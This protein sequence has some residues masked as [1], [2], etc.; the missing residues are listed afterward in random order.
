MRSLSEYMTDVRNAIEEYRETMEDIDLEIIFESFQCKML[1]DI[2]DQL[3]TIIKKRKDEQAEIDKKEYKNSWERP[4]VPAP[5]ADFKQMFFW[6]DFTWDKI[7]DS[8]VKEWKAGDPNGMKLVKRICSN[9]S[10]SIPGMIILKSE[11]NSE[12][13]FAG[14]IIKA[15]WDIRYYSLLGQYHKLNGALKPKEAEG[16]VEDCDFWTIEIEQDQLANA[17]K[18]DRFKAKSGSIKMGDPEEYK[19]IAEANRER[20]RKLAEKKKIEKNAD[21]GMY[22]RIMDYVQKVMDVCEIF[23]KDPVKYASYEYS[24]QTLLMLI[25]DRQRYDSRASK[26]YGSDGLMY[27]FNI[28]LTKKLSIAKGD[29]FAHEKKEFTEAKNKIEEIFKKIDQK[30]IDM[31]I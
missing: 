31:N 23:S 24:I 15:V 25:G 4:S 7:K 2:R 29:S 21:D 9:R 5:P 10:N 8:Q 22:E 3:Q 11:D 16:V 1:Q 19:K 13:K 17:I 26:Y 28:Y 27:L 6:H 14:V 12:Y 18:N 20:Y 30:I